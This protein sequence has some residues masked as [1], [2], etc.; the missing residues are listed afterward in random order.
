MN[1]DECQWFTIN[2][3]KWQRMTMNDKEGQWIRMNDNECQ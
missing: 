3:N 2:Y 1:D